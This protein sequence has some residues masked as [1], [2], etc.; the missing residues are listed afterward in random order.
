MHWKSTVLVCY[1][2]PKWS[3]RPQVRSFRPQWMRLSQTDAGPL[4][5]AP[6][7]PADGPDLA[8]GELRAGECITCHRTSDLRLVRTA[9]LL[10][11]IE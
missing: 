1:P 10:A 3:F 8:A 5:P 9:V 6:A 7:C 11:V 4:S 2:T